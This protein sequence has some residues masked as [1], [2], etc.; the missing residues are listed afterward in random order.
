MPHCIV[1]HRHLQL[2]SL[3]DGCVWL[4]C[5]AGCSVRLSH[6]EGCGPLWHLWCLSCSSA[7]GGGCG[8]SVGIWASSAVTQVEVHSLVGVVCH[9]GIWVPNVPFCHIWNNGNHV[10]GS[11]LCQLGAVGCSWG[12]SLEGVDDVWP[13]LLWLVWAVHPLS[14]QICVH[15]FGAVGDLFPGMLDGKVI[16]SNLSQLTGGCLEW[17][18]HKFS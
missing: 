1:G 15:R 10:L 7:L 3:Q 18:G 4:L 12:Q 14:W 13:W 2:W 6:L 11:L 8:S 16:H 17:L 5:W 9:H